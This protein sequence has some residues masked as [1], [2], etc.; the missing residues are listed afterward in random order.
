MT[1]EVGAVSRGRNIVCGLGNLKRETP[2][3]ILDRTW[4][5]LQNALAVPIALVLYVSL[6]L[7]GFY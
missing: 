1:G 3:T 6:N 4:G 5:S 2:L 7:S